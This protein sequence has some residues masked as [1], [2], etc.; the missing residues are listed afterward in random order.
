M[1]VPNGSGLDR[2]SSRDDGYGGWLSEIRLGFLRHDE[3]PFSH[4]KES[5]W[6]GNLEVLFVSP[7]WLSS[8]WSPRPHLGFSINSDPGD[9]TNQIYAGLSWEW[10]FWGGMLAG[11]SLGGAVHDGEDSTNDPNRK[12]LGCP[13]LF[14]ESVEVGYRFADRHAVT[15]FLDHISNASICDHNEGLES[16]GVRYGYKF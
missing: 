11:F 12:E 1:P 16:F 10:Q 3:G 6:D 13:V 4:R 15:L 7:S 5:G 14:R 9:N 8:I 2:G